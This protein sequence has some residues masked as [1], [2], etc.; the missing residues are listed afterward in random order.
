M[1]N[2]PLPAGF[3]QFPCSNCGGS[4]LFKPGT[5]HLKCP[6]CGT[7]NSIEIDDTD[8]RYLTEHDFLKELEKQS[9]KQQEAPDATEAE[10]VRC[11]NCG[12]TTTVTRD[13]TADR[14]PYCDSP[15]VIQNAFSYK[16]NVQAVLPFAVDNQTAQT[17]YRDWLKSRWFAP[18]DFTRRATREEALK[19]I[20]MPFWTYDAHTHTRY[21]GKRGD[22]YYVTNTVTVQRNGRMVQEDRQE[23][24]IHWTNVSGQVFVPFDDVLVPASSSLPSDLQDRLAPWPLQNLKPFRQE[25]LSG[26]VTETY[27]VSVGE[28]FDDAKSRMEPAILRTIRADIGGDEQRILDAD[29]R[30]S[31]ITFKHILLPLWTS[32]YR[33]NNVTYRFMIN[34][35]TG[36]VTGNRPWSVWKIAGA[37]L[38]GMALAGGIFSM[39]EQMGAFK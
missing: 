31:K 11:T 39:L 38:A 9:Q 33:Y 36:E 29:T 19:G 1:K 7:E 20:Y 15:L 28:G 16:F 21:R 8:D 5:S 10:A 25:F 22:A 34:A 27:R 4:L 13:R 3:S 14:C 26:F 30:Y 18:N 12:A 6:N 32:A 17:S 35:Q 2:T 24:R 23:R 37:V